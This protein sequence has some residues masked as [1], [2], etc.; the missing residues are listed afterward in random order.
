M[1]NRFNDA[2]VVTFFHPYLD[3]Q[4]SPSLIY[5]SLLVRGA[6][7]KQKQPAQFLQ[8]IF[9]LLPTALF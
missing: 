2:F 8:R 5:R 6:K 4:K 9:Y 7:N 3:H 1:D